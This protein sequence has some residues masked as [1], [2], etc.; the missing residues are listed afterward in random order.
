MASI[1]FVEDSIKYAL[2]Q[3]V[4]KEKIVVGIPFYGRMWSTDGTILGEGV[5]LKRINTLAKTY[6]SK[7]F[8]DPTTGTPV[9]HIT[10]TT[11]FTLNG[12]TIKSGNYAIW[13][14]NAD[15]IKQKLALVE[16]YGIKGAG[17]WERGAGDGGCLG[18][19]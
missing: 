5:S 18:L 15:T 4:P 6:P 9:L 10:V 12:K 11:P 1:G 16:K 13:Y 8:Y 2:S 14:E 3:Q 17:N 19:L 7:V